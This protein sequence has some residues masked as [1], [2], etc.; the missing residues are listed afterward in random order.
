MLTGMRDVMTPLGAIPKAGLDAL[1]AFGQQVERLQYPYIDVGGFIVPGRD[2]V[3][4]KPPGTERDRH[5]AAAGAERWGP[6]PREEAGPAARARARTAEAAPG[7]SPHAIEHRLTTLK[8]GL[9]A[10]V[11]FHPLARVVASTEAAVYLNIPIG[12]IP[13][14]A[15]G[16]RLTLEVPLLAREQLSRSMQLSGVPEV[17][18]WA[19]WEGGP[20]HGRLID[21][22]H[23]NPDGAICANMPGQWMLAVYPLHDYVAFCVL[24]VAKVLH[25]YLLGYYPGPQHYP[26]VVRVRRD[27][28]DEFCGC[29]EFRRYRDCCRAED[30]A[31]RPYAL[32]REAHLARVLYLGELAR[33]GRAASPPDHLLRHGLRVV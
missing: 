13:E 9:P 16:T 11:T 32:W 5:A 22:H 24:W 29:G 25:E 12:V 33:Q 10:L 15:I 2:P 3:A 8:L 30:R 20:L 7:A 19:V 28:P 18:A 27:R 1:R 31:Q 26:A 23:R 6:A 4:I 21:S 17:R 14:L